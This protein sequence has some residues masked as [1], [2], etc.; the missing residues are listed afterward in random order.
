MFGQ[1]LGTTDYYVERD[2]HRRDLLKQAQAWELARQAQAGQPSN[3]ERAAEWVGRA[4]AGLGAHLV[5]L[6]Q[7]L[8]CIEPQREPRALADKG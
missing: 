5:E 4:L 6:G 3:A 1:G 8:Q 2:P 7:R